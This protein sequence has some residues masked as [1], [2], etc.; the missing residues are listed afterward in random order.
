M[1]NT[2]SSFEVYASAHK[3]RANVQELLHDFGARRGWTLLAKIFEIR[4]TGAF[5][6]FLDAPTAKHLAS[7]MAFED[8]ILR[9]SMKVDWHPRAWKTRFLEDGDDT[10]SIS[11]EYK[12][13]G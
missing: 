8:E 4:F 2:L 1:S 5:I 10:P 12:R 7:V 11:P 9:A 3:T 6:A 13:R